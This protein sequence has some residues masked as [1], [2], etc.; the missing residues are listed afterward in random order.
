MKFS[1]ILDALVAVIRLSDRVG[2]LEASVEETTRAFREEIQ[3]RD[4]TFLAHDRRIQKIENLME[5]AGRFSRTGKP[6]LTDGT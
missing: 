2:R 1:R 3:H 4:Q 5:F 6:E